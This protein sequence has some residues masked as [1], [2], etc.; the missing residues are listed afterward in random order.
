MTSTNAN[1]KSDL[2]PWL[3]AVLA[4][5]ALIASDHA[6]ALPN[7]YDEQELLVDTLQ[8]GDNYGMAVA[9]S[10]DLAIVGASLDDTMGHNSGCVYVF[11]LDDDGTWVQTQRLFASNANS[12]ANFGAA[13]AIEGDIALVGAP[14]FGS[15]SDDLGPLGEGVVYAFQRNE[16]G[17]F[18]EV[19]FIRSS[20]AIYQ[21]EFGRDIQLSG[22][23]MIVSRWN[24][25]DISYSYDAVFAFV[26]DAEGV[27]HEEQRLLPAGDQAKM[28]VATSIA[29]SG[30]T[31]LVSSFDTTSGSFEA[32]AAV[33]ER[34]ASGTWSETGRIH[35]PGPLYRGFACSLAIDGDVAVVGK[36]R[37][38]DSGMQLGAAHVFLR[39]GADWQ[40]VARLAAPDEDALGPAPEFSYAVAISDGRILVGAP[41]A[42][43][44]GMDSGAAYAFFLNEQDEWVFEQSIQ[45][46]AVV[47]FA[48]FGKALAIDGNLGLYGVP[49]STSS[50]VTGT[51]YVG[52]WSGHA[53]ADLN[54]DGLING[55][56][57][58]LL[59]SDWGSLE[60]DADLNGDGIVNGSDLA[61][62]LSAWSI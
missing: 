15:G 8:V 46:A 17:L 10:G 57:L 45:P 12:Y 26:R 48:K 61:I 25:S 43:A 19:Q 36:S 5:L 54:G 62:L 53:L 11:E 34:D 59:L 44:L 1:A 33:F 39:D 35:N 3:W 52:T 49:R 42:D 23:I 4:I 18:E 40:H 38:E 56:D 50:Q 27:W 41:F 51:A 30:S 31:A 14:K 13:V 47:A 24:F 16:S 9:I 28:T 37:D 20:D 29:L 22:N 2:I 55:A 60:S 21:H 7:A 58:T 6:S 32:Y